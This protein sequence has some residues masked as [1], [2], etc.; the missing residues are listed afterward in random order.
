[1]DYWYRLG[2]RN[3][4]AQAAGL[5]LAR[6]LAEDPFAIAE[7]ITTRL[8]AGVTDLTALHSAAYGRVARATAE[9]QLDWVGPKEFAARHGVVG[10]A[11]RHFASHWGARGEQRITLRPSPV[12]GRG[13][14]FVYD[15]TW[16]EYAVL[17][18]DVTPAAV[19]AAFTHAS[20][21][22]IHLEPVRFA[23]LV[24]EHEAEIRSPKAAT[25]VEVGVR[26]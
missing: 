2:L 15:P 3:A 23:E 25:A 6:E 16:D 21:V 26:L 1:V 14:L 19:E 24:H 12:G 5:C 22:D 20:Q 17:A 10:T 9:R 13:L 18:T 8:D 11:D 7:R 4:Y